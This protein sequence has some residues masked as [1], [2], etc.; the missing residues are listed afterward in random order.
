MDWPVAVVAGAEVSFKTG[1]RKKNRFESTVGA[2]LSHDRPYKGERSHRNARQ[3]V[4]ETGGLGPGS[5]PSLVIP[6]SVAWKR[7]P[8]SRSRS[9]K[10]KN[11]GIKRSRPPS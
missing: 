8:F 4:M 3:G 1:R 6:V 9:I 11:E 10:K 2:I 7:G 5:V